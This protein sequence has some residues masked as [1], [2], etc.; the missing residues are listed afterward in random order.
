M[1]IYSIQ[2]R[3]IRNDSDTDVRENIADFLCALENNGQILYGHLTV[4]NEYG[5]DL[6]VCTPKCDSLQPCHD[7]IYVTRYRELLQ[8]YATVEIRQMGENADG[9][10][11]CSCQK[12]TAMEMQTFYDDTDSVFTCCTCGKPIAL[13]DLPYLLNQKDHYHIVNWQN[14]Y[15]ATDTLWMDS[16]S[17][18]FT[19]NQLVNPH[20]ALNTI[21]REIAQEMEKNAGITCYYNI[22]D[23]LTKKVK[24]T[25]VDGNPVR[26]CPECGKAME[27]VKICDDYERC[28]CRDCKL[29]SNLPTDDPIE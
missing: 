5:Y 4:K 15:R 3:E 11:Y 18:R 27:Y 12:R 25:R 6:H 19:G 24:F 13:Y 10:E 8:Q 7:S 29:S 9:Q 21:G 28:V 1:Y 23:D 26:L 14:T 16:L 2:I 22:F 17:D 20:S